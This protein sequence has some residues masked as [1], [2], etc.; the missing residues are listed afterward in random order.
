MCIWQLGFSNLS[1]SLQ[2]WTEC[3]RSPTPVVRF[4]NFVAAEPLWQQPNAE[5]ST[6][7]CFVCITVAFQNELEDLRTYGIQWPE[8]ACLNGKFYCYRRQQL[9]IYRGSRAEGAYIYP[10][11][12]L[13]CSSAMYHM[14]KWLPENH[15]CSQ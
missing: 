12:I 11:S 13:M 1:F 4:A 10:F 8:S 2:Q 5:M 15:S 14:T 9:Q 7:Y 6:V 3:W